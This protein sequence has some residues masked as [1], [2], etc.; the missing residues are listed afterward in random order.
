VVAWA[1]LSLPTEA[2]RATLPEA[3]RNV[4]SFDLPTVRGRFAREFH[5][6]L[7]SDY[8]SRLK[9]S[10]PSVLRLRVS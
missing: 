6:L 1:N 2:A 5:Q 8:A 10:P 3:L 9:V 7:A 4:S